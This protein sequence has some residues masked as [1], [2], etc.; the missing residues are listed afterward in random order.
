MVAGSLGICGAWLGKTVPAGNIA[1]PKGFFEHI[2]LRE[3][4]NKRILIQLDCDP[5]GVQ[6]L[7]GLQS[8]PVIPELGDVICRIIEKEGYKPS[9]PWLFKDAKL[10]LTW[11]TFHAAFPDARWVLVRRS[12]DDIVRSC[13]NTPFMSQ[14]STD[15]ELWH[16][17]IKQYQLR[18]D[19]LRETVACS[20]D[21]QAEDLVHGNLEPLH[22]LVDELDLTW[23][24]KEL[25]NFI[26]TDHWHGQKK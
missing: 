11:P 19:Q 25:G 21:I 12:P 13:L 5:L 22:A 26:T 10:T 14:H 6:R 15:P 1:N 20:R 16:H 9:Q 18:L 2:V 8:L 17:W 7:P 23:K 3:Q 24:E 4:V